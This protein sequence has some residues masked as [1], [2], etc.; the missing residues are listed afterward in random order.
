MPDREREQHPLIRHGFPDW[1]A[2]VPMNPAKPVWVP[3]PENKRVP[4][5][6]LIS[7]LDAKVGTTI[8]SISILP[9]LVQALSEFTENPAWAN[10]PTEPTSV[11]RAEENNWEVRVGDYRGAFNR[12]EIEQR[13][14]DTLRRPSEQDSK[15]K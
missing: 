9:E 8:G 13:L 10:L 2:G 11:R 15:D 3:F 14:I 12:Q 1:L 5:N 4:S 6:L 7:A